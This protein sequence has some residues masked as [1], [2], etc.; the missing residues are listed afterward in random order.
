MSVEA[1]AMLP[2]LLAVIGGKQNNGSVINS[3]LLEPCDKP[4]ESFAKIG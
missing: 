1:G 4:A 2:E 3:F